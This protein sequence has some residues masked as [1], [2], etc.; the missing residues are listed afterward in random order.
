M[1]NVHQLPWLA[2]LWARLGSNVTKNM[3]DQDTKNKETLTSVAL[4]MTQQQQSTADVQ[5]ESLEN[6]ALVSH[7]KRQAQR[8][9]LTAPWRLQAWETLAHT[10]ISTNA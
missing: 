2:P 9:I 1:K 10:N 4:V 8:A 3:D 5:A 6:A 7:S